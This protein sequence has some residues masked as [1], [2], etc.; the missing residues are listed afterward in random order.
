MH[1]DNHNNVTHKQAN[2]LTFSLLELLVA[3]K[4]QARHKQKKIE[5]KMLS[6]SQ[7]KF[8]SLIFITF[9]LVLNEG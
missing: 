7:T 5:I 8:S 2:L 1:M 4:N 3:A 6:H 9:L